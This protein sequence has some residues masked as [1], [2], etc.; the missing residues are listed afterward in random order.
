MKIYLDNCTFNRPFDNQNGIRV[1]I[2]TEAK[3]YIQEQIE[4]GKLNLVWSYILDFENEQ[5]PFIERKIS[6]SKWKKNLPSATWKKAT[7]F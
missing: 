7:L 2:E 6:I 4:A 1:R 5:S 3:L